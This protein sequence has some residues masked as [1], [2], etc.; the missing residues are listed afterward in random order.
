VAISHDPRGREA[1][2]KLSPYPYNCLAEIDGRI[3]DIRPMSGPSMDLG[4]EYVVEVGFLDIDE[5]R[6]HLAIGREVKIREGRIV[7]ARAFILELLD[8]EVTDGSSTY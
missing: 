4:K 1:P 6:P 8:R 7:V 2:L 5:A 3:F